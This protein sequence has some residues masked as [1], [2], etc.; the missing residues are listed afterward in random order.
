MQEMGLF[1]GSERTKKSEKLRKLN[2][3]TRS[4]SSS[5]HGKDNN[6]FKKSRKTGYLFHFYAPKYGQ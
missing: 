3:N 1:A 5:Y 4:I 2:I 6:K